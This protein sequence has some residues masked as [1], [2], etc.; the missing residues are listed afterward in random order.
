MIQRIQSL[1][2]LGASICFG[3]L[4]KIPFATSEVSIPF[5]FEDQVYNIFDN[6]L[7]IILTSLGVLLSLGAIFLFQNRPLQLTL[8]KVSAV[9]SILLPTLA[10]LLVVNEGTYTSEADQINDNLGVFLPIISLIMSL[11]AIRFI[12]KDEKIV[13]SMD[14]LR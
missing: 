10:V 8:S 13:R 2:L 11:L 4:F 5:L 9:V 14:R 12:H 1:L 6:T 3:L 7:L